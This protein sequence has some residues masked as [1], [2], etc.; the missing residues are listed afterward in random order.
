[1]QGFLCCQCFVCEHSLD[2]WQ[3]G[4]QISLSFCKLSFLSKLPWFCN[5]RSQVFSWLWTL[6]SC[7]IDWNV[8]HNLQVT[9]YCYFMWVW[10]QIISI[11]QL[12]L[13]LGAE[14]QSCR[15]IPID[16]SKSLG[17]IN[18]AGVRP[19]ICFQWVQPLKGTVSGYIHN[20]IVNA[21]TQS[22]PKRRHLQ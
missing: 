21:S 18:A 6:C 11:R 15:T 17:C 13:H 16:I 12:Q 4:L 22:R 2:E 7:G 8:R 20:T 5:F 10:K 9:P 1:M 14:V 3:P 19:N